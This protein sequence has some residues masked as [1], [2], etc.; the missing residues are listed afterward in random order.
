MVSFSSFRENLRPELSVSKMRN[1]ARLVSDVISCLTFHAMEVSSD[2][3]NAITNAEG[4]GSGVVVGNGFELAGDCPEGRVAVDGAGAGPVRLLRIRTQR[5][6]LKAANSPSS[7]TKQTNSN[8]IFSI[9]VTPLSPLPR[10]SHNLI[11]R[12]RNLRISKYGAIL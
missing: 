7:S 11:K 1:W 4:A 6:P 3:N 12:F 8:S 2:A 10:P 9:V 5:P